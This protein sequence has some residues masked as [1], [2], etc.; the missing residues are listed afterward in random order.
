[1]S[2]DAQTCTPAAGKVGGIHGHC[3][4]IYD[5]GA[6]ISLAERN[7]GDAY[8]DLEF[9]FPRGLD[10]YYNSGFIGMVHFGVTQ[11]GQY[12]RCNHAPG[13]TAYSCLGGGY[14]FAGVENSFKFGGHWLSF[15]AAGKDRQW[16]EGTAADGSCAPKQIRARCMFS[17]MAQAS[18][19]CPQ[20]CG[21]LTVAQCGACING[22]SV[23]I[24]KQVWDRAFWQGACPP[25]T[26][27]DVLA[28][29]A[30]VDP[31]GDAVI[32]ASL[33]LDPK[34]LTWGWWHNSS[35]SQDVPVNATKS[36]VV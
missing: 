29:P 30:P 2:V 21:S 7:C 25:A 20:G 22:L 10:A 32:W 9:T 16:S 3:Y 5:A 17:L 33:G 35:S 12:L 34:N 28:D 27:A 14:Q 6:G 26:E 11:W 31:E 1:M 24:A 36:I 18:G 23:Q 8:G 13:S 4:H 15:P 19:R